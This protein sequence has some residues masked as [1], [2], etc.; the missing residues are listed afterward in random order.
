MR[1]NTKKQLSI[2][3]FGL[4]L[5]LSACSPAAEETAPPEPA[6]PAFRSIVSATGVVVP[7]QEALL[8]VSA[9][10]V[11]E[12]VLVSKGDEVSVGQLLVQL[13]GTEQQAA[14]VSAAVLELANAQFAL[15]R[16]FKDTDLL[17]ARALRSAETAEQALEDLN[18]P[19]LQ[20]ALALQAVADAQKAVDTT[21]RNARYTQST[22]S[23]AD[24]DAQKAQLVM[25]R[26][27]LDR[28]N[29]DF[30]P[31]ANKPE[32]N[33]T[34]A[35]F[36]ATQAAAQQIYDDA[37]RRLNA[38]QGTGSEVDI[39]VAEAEYITAQAALLQAE[40]DLERVL[41]GPD[42]GEIA[43]LEAQI[44]K[45]QREFEIYSDGPDPDD[46]TLAEARIANAEAHLAAAEELLSDLELKAPFNGVISAVHVNSSEWVAP[47]SP[48]LLLG[49]LNH[50]QIK[51]TDLSEID[52]ARISL[53]DTAVVTFD[54]LP[55]L[56]L[57]GTV[58][59]IAPKADEGSGVN[60][61][62]IIELSEIPAALRW[63]M[64]AFVDI[65]V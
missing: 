49:D 47:G 40:R 57:E 10:G 64:T 9:G 38:M 21:E 56:V 58:I 18:N 27:A 11:V 14:A 12:E 33:L 15:D 48:V 61:P 35:H 34:R 24:I 3:A 8:S 39:N 31:H 42:P 28:A 16:L 36:L 25:A 43:L 41:D 45:G 51:T 19:E 62:V 53:D 54:A 63:G 2:V 44:D 32:D 55:D 6:A 60:F 7:E 23:Q 46:V 59:S 50:L 5:F 22:A 4:V 20:E 65:D 52:V 1:I 30:E 17:A 13:E 29:E 26:D 37:V